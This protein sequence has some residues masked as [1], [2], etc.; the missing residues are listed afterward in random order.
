MDDVVEDGAAEDGAAEDGVQVAASL[1]EWLGRLEFVDPPTDSVTAR[2]VA[3]VAAWGA[4]QGWRVYRRAPSVAPLPPPMS[5]QHSV[6]D[7]ACARPDGP[8]VVVEIDRSDRQ[9][10]IDKLIAEA[11][12]GRVPIWVRWGAGR[13]V[14]P[15]APV[16]MVTVEVT[17]RAAA[18]G[19]GRVFTRSLT[20][21]RPPPAHSAT[22]VGAATEAALLPLD[23]PPVR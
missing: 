19:S 23:D 2:I 9:R 15:A 16:Q 7:V 17:R 22:G 20:P 3:S 4:G 14:A 12:A 10:T 13:F 6:L 11:G 5:N 21:E 8:P 1:A 18:D